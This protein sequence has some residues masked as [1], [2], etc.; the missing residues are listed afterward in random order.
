MD[1]G[2]CLMIF[3]FLL[4]FRCL[5]LVFF[6]VPKNVSFPISLDLHKIHSSRSG[7]NFGSLHFLGQAISRFR[8]DQAA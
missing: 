5:L 6:P 4:V 2:L 8:Q 7:Q 3:V 1:A